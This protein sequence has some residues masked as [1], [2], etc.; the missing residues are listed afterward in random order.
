[1]IAFLQKQKDEAYTQFIVERSFQNAYLK[2]ANTLCDSRQEACLRLLEEDGSAEVIIAQE[3]CPFHKFAGR[4]LSGTH[5][6]ETCHELDGI[7]QFPNRRRF[8][9]LHAPE[10]SRYLELYEPSWD[11]Y[12]RESSVKTQRLRKQKKM[13]SVLRCCARS[14]KQSMDS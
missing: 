14:L 12:I 2:Q 9:M 5:Y 3:S 6:L 1:M 7:E 11:E 10:V 8:R 4:V 13:P